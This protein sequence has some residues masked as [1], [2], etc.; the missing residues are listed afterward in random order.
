MRDRNARIVN[1]VIYGIEED[2]EKK[3]QELALEIQELRGEIEV[4]FR[5]GRKRGKRRPWIVYE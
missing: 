5:A 2:D 4:K 1:V 3:V